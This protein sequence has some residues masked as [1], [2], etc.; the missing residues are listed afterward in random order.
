MA[1]LWQDIRYAIRSLAKTPGFVAVAALTLGL[2]IGANSAIF[3]VVNAVMLRSLPVADPASLVLLTDPGQAATNV[4]TTE[5][6]ER[7]IL[8]YQEFLQLREHN[9]VFSGMFA[10]QS[11]PSTLDVATSEGA[12]ASAKARVQLVSGD[13]FDVL[14]IQPAIGRVFT[15]AEDGARGA[16]PV[17]VVSNGFWERELSAD[18]AAL[19]KTLRIG[20][21]VFRV[22][23]VAPPGFRGMLV[24][25]ETEVWLPITMQAQALPG[26]DYL[27]PRDTIWLQVMGRLKPGVSTT[28]AQAAVN[29]E[30]QQILRMWAASA[31]TENERRE[32]FNQKLILQAGARGASR[33][34]GAFSDPLKMLMAMVGL[35]LLIACANIA[36]LTLARASGRQRELGVR[37]A[38]GAGR[39]RIMRQVLT[40]SMLIAA[41]GGVVGTAFATWTTSLLLTLVR[42]GFDGVTL[43]PA[44]DL[45][46][47]LFTA[48]ASI[49]TGILFGLGP[50]LGAARLDINGVMAANVRGA[51]GARGRLDAGRA[52]VVAQVA[53]SLLLCVGAGLFV[54]SLHNLLSL[55]LGIDRE[56][57]L[58]ARIDLAAAGYKQAAFPTVCERLRER[59]KTIPGV[60]GASVSNDGLFTGDAGDHIAIDGG[61]KHAEDEMASNWTLVGP[62]YFR[63]VGIQ[64]L[65]GRAIEEADMQ[66]G[67]PVCVVNQAFAKYFFGDESP[68]GHHVTDLYPTT[69]TT[70][71]IVGVVAD[72]R[73]HQLRGNIRQ[74][75]YGNYAHPIGTLSEPALVVSASGDPAAIVETV[76]R[77]IAAAEPSLPVLNIRTLDQQL[78]RGTIVQRLTAD[79]SACFGGLALLMAAIGLYGVMSYSMARRTAEIGIRMALGA[80]RGGVLWMVLRESLALC[81]VGVAIGL[82]AAWWLAPAVQNQ[83]FGL[84]AADPST[85]A[86]AIA[87]IVCAALLAGYLPASRAARVDPMTALRCE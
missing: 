30:F 43:D 3:A 23:G 72:A 6:G 44:R 5:H 46:V 87:V 70:F 84:T 54:R 26:R 22:I 10:A 47:L 55:T 17:A 2:G 21:G 67:R 28:Q 82:A 79:L 1:S 42:R 83:L 63:T 78:D 76:R 53:L 57:L 9:T 33:L 39:W 31:P 50:A 75:F 34:R 36:N 80:S 11:V 8:S 56:H 60:R 48:A 14:G 66:S 29:V 49:F 7:H 61:I 71:E 81:G 62:S 45:R 51:A 4:E 69:V 38:L 32:M 59:L 74:R 18:R 12:P 35:V 15:A 41:L 52:L 64:I 86:I 27:T 37:L 85:I 13:F 20:G 40:E 58:M 16:N 25:N 19:G 65:R 77:T 24:G 68:L 73:E